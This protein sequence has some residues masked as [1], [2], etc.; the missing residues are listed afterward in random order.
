M[1]PQRNTAEGIAVEPSDRIMSAMTRLGFTKY[2]VL[3]YWTLLVNGPS[4]AREISEESGI[5]YNR[6]YDTVT[7]L[8]ARGFVTEVEGTPRVYAA[9]PPA[10]AFMRLKGEIDS[11]RKLFEMELSKSKRK[12]HERPAIWRTTKIDEAIEMVR[13][14]IE[15]SEYEIILVA[16]EKFL[17][18]IQGDL[19]K[20]LRR[21]VTLSLYTGGNTS[22]N[23]LKGNGNLFIRRFHR[24][25][26]FIGM[27]DGKEVIDIQN[28][29]LRPR[30]P[31]SFKATYPEIIFAQYAFV[32]EAFQESELLIEDI[33]RKHD[34]RFFTT[35]H[36]VDLIRRHLPKGE[37]YAEVVGKNLSTG[38]VET[39]SGK[40]V[41]YT[42]VLEEG[43]DNFDLKLNGKIVKIGGMFAVLEEYES[44]R[45]RL[46]LD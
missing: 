25:N 30:N 41:G 34:V 13:E 9:F 46:I 11:L 37:V 43:I 27:F 36:A 42:V 19:Q 26:H 33:N 39:L 5:P 23:G 1:K 24:L 4:T 15:G 35:F 38:E 16:P 40:V 7:S 21:G 44:T 8:K 14:S 22:L 31:P 17:E 45:I 20:A 18:E 29:G 2:E 6:V 32:R 28:I 3:T 12:E 10:I